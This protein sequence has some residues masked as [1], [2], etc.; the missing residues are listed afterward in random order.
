VAKIASHAVQK[1]VR[2]EGRK[3]VAVTCHYDVVDWLQ[4][5]WIL[6]HGDDDLH[7]EVYFNDAPPSSHVGRVP[8]SAWSCLRPYH[9]LNADLHPRGPLLRGARGRATRRVR[10]DAP[11]RP[12]P[13][14]QDVTGC[15]RLVT[16]PDWQ[17]IGLAMALIDVVGSAYKALGRRRTPTQ[18]TR[19]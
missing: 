5:D 18:R 6:E 9:Y 11:L 4:P 14:V 7:A 16:L 13:T 8:H 2:R 3:F 12:H 17:G 10:R 19:R 1:F 15:S